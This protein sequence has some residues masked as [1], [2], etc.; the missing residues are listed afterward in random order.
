MNS[1]AIGTGEILDAV[2]AALDDDETD[3]FEGG[4]HPST[5]ADRL[6]VSEGAAQSHMSELAN[7][8]ELRRVDGINPETTQ[9]RTSYLPTDD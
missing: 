7:R 5:V 8:G 3:A 1:E 9:P 6:S 4:V 2:E